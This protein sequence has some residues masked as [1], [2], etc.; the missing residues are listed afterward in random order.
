MRTG[1]VV[2][3]RRSSLESESE[4]ESEKG[5]SSSDY[6]EVTVAVFV[7]CLREWKCQGAHCMKGKRASQ[8]CWPASSL[9][10]VSGCHGST[11]CPGICV[12][13]RKAHSISMLFQRSKDE[14]VDDEAERTEAPPFVKSLSWALDGNAIAIDYRCV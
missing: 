14:T 1:A 11:I 9:S 2:S 4:S 10:H 8:V 6:R 3:G 7:I 5:I 12:L 13:G